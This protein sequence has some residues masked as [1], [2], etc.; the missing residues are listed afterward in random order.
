MDVKNYNVTNSRGRN[1]LAKNIE[2]QYYQRLR[3]LPEN[4]KQTVF[5]DV[6]GQN[7]SEKNLRSLYDS[8]MRRTKKEVEVIF[9]K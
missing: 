3:H 2:K 6:R 7:V 5:I 1:K 4:T 8:I 9:Q